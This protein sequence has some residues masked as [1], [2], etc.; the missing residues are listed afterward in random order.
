MYT[1][2]PDVYFSRRLRLHHVADEED[3]PVWSGKSITEA[4]EYLV[5]NDHRAFMMDGG[6]DGG[7]YLVTVVRSLT[8]DEKPE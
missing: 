1:L 6:Q 2:Y 8:D 7:R 3:E 5:E 4:L